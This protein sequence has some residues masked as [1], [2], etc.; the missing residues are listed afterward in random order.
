MIDIALS[1]LA[2]VAGGLTVEIYAAARAPL[3]YQDQHGFHLG[4]EPPHPATDYPGEKP[5]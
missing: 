5:I 3:G 1:V 2:L 4:I